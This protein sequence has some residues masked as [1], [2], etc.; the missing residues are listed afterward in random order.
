MEIKVNDEVFGCNNITSSVRL[1]SIPNRASPS[2]GVIS[3]KTSATP[4]RNQ[5]LIP[6]TI[7]IVVVGFC[8][9]PPHISLPVK[10]IL[11]FKKF[12]RIISV[13]NWLLQV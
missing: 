1:M 8:C 13:C 12:Q 10:L 2:S 3:S 5:S 4:G 7:C 6:N 9:F 11:S